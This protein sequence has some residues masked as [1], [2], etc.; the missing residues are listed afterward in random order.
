M[1]SPRSLLAPA[2]VVTTA[3]LTALVVALATASPAAA[4][5]HSI[6]R[7]DLQGT[8]PLT[9]P[10]SPSPVIAGVNP[11]GAPWVIDEDSE[12]RVREDGR[13]RVELK[14]LV[15]PNRVPGN[16]VPLMAASLVCDDMVVDST[17]AFPV[18]EDGNGLIED[19]ISGTKDCD[20]PV[21]LVRS[22]TN[23]AAL[24]NYFA[25]AMED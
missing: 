9:D 4:R 11:G 24:G 2:A 21:V 15:I 7:E 10:V 14:H 13:I 1:R 12:A 16:P 20:D 25:V 17:Q 22:A 23:P 18:T 3:L 5:G 19:R 6:L 8:F